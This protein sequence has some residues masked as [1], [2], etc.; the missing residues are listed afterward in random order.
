MVDRIG[1]LN[2]TFKCKPVVHTADLCLAMVPSKLH[3]GFSC[4]GPDGDAQNCKTENRLSNPPCLC[5]RFIS[6]EI[7]TLHI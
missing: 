2:V 1:V 3:V 5:Y 7:A 4:Q 6:L